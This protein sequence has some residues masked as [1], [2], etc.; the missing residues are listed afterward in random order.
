MKVRR[1]IQCLALGVVAVGAFAIIGASPALAKPASQTSAPCPSPKGTQGLQT[2]INVGVSATTNGNVTTY[3]LF[4]NDQGAENGVPGLVKYCVYPTGASAAPTVTV[5]AEGGENEDIPWI[6]IKSNKSPYNFAFQRPGGNDTNIW[7][8]EN[9]E[10]TLMGTANWGNDVPDSQKIVL[11]VADPSLCGTSPT[12]FVKP[13]AVC[14]AGAGNTDAAYNA[15][16]SAFPNCAPPPSLGFEAQQTAEFGDE[17]ML[18]KGGNLQSMTVDF[19][20]YGCSDSGDWNLGATAPCVTT[21]TPTFTVPG[22]IT[23]HIYAVN[24]GSPDTVGQLIATS[25]INPNIPYRPSAD[26]GNCPGGAIPSQNIEAGSQFR[27]AAGDCVYSR[28]VLLDFTGFTFPNG[29]HSFSVGEK[30]IWTV[31]FNTTHY[32][33]N[34]IGED[35]PAGCFQ[36]NGGDPG[37]GYD[38]LN[39]GALTYPNAPYAGTDVNADQAFRAFGSSP[40]PPNT[41]AAESGWTGNLPLGKIITQ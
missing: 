9:D 23:A 10:T 24:P 18:G 2:D 7:F 21:G 5:N 37:C 3:R 12:C 6:A 39:V 35:G 20:S 32:G 16:P 22:G 40:Q 36:A 25:T 31:Q 11:H 1:R 41:L 19:Q 17:V 38:S 30:V 33:Y 15:I 34:P 8:D 26:P 14:D 28:S 29:A 27:N 4:S 13:G